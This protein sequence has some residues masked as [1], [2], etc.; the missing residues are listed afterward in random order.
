MYLIYIQYVSHI[1]TVCISYIYSMYLIYI[2]YVSHIYTVCISYI[3]S[4]YL[5]YIQYVSHIYTVCISYIYS[6]Y[7][8]YIQYVS[9][10]YTVCI[11]FPILGTPHSPLTM[12]VLLV[13]VFPLWLLS[14]LKF[15]FIITYSRIY[16]Y[17]ISSNS[18]RPPNRPRPRIDR[19]RRLEAGEI[20]RVPRIERAVRPTQRE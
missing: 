11:L 1:Y 9:H 8:I 6:M 17:R 4:M 3:Y 12:H 7:L 19:V 2:Q 15:H 18:S 10:I 13:V 5:I 14:C 20:Q 16:R